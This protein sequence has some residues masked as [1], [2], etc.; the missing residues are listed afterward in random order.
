V[1]ETDSS[2]GKASAGT[3]FTYMCSCTGMKM[4]EF[5][6]INITDAESASFV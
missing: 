1:W 4:I 6:N 5:F 3:E 2:R